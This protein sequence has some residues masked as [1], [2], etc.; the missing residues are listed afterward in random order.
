[1]TLFQEQI[2]QLTSGRRYC[3]VIMSYN[4]YLTFF[5]KSQSVVEADAGYACIRADQISGAGE[6]LRGKIQLAIDG[7]SLVIADVSEPSPNIYYELGYAVARGKPVLVAAHDGVVLPTDL[8]GMEVMRWA[9]SLPAM[10]NFLAALRAH[11]APHRDV[12]LVRAMLIPAEPAPSFILAS[13]S[14][15][16]PPYFRKDTIE[17]RTYGDHLG[18]VGI[19]RAFGSIFGES[20]VPELVSAVPSTKDRPLVELLGQDANYY[21]IGSPK[22]NGATGMFL[23]AMQAGRAPAWQFRLAPGEPPEGE[24]ELVG[25]VDSN[26]VRSEHRK[27][28]WPPEKPFGDIGLIVRGPHPRFQNRMVTILAGPH[29]GGTGGACLAA[30]NSKKIQVIADR[31]P[32]GVDL[33]TRERTV[34]VQVRVEPAEDHYISEAGVTIERVGVYE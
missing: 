20:I 32:Q 5:E 9:D 16:S 29:S 2:A 6:D 10:P 8:Q 4:G 22:V 26:V 17:K 11:L 31:L 33:A 3:F 13:P 24:F 21:L 15:P 18:I 23:E 1:V 25:T 27:A 30:T 7:A 28:A 19:L 12:S 34:W 14:P